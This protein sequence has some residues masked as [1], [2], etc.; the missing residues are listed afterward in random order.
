MGGSIYSPGP[1]AATASFFSRDFLIMFGGA[2]M[3]FYAS[4]LFINNFVKVERYMQI[5]GGSMS[6]VGN[7][8]S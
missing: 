7:G 5:Y 8:I 6:R 2:G 4:L 3:S 1:R